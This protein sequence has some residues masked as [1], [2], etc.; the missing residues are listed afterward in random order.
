MRKAMILSIFL[1][2]TL[3][4]TSCIG[5]K[6]KEDLN[7]EFITHLEYYKDNYQSKID[8]YNT[9][10][11]RTILNVVKIERTSYS[12]FTTAT[13]SGVIFYQDNVNFY[14]L[15]NNHVAYSS[16]PDRTTYLIYDYQGNKYTG[17]LVASDSTYDLAVLSIRKRDYV[18]D[19]IIFSSFNP[20]VGERTAILGY[21][22]EQANVITLGKVLSYQKVNI[23]DSTN[24]IIEVDFEIIVSDTPVKQGSSGSVVI[25]DQFQV[26][27][28]LYAGSFR[29]SEKF[30]TYS[31][32]IPV[33]KVIEFLIKYDFSFDEVSS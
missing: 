3:F 15:T 9:L 18:I 8:Y 28:I 24:N 21:P 12:P 27:G 13:G 32:S 30:S 29:D 19:N 17:M 20:A 5:I 14:I 10:S 26:I 23:K 2:F 11:T 16:N 4:L 7:N 1:V 6:T 25:N 22:F 31:Y 33:E